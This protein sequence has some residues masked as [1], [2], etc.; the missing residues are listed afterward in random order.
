MKGRGTDNGLELADQRQTAES[1]EDD[2]AN[3]I[4][5]SNPL[6]PALSSEA[7]ER[8]KTVFEQCLAIA[9]PREELYNR[10][11]QRVE[12]MFAAG[13]IDEVQR[14]RQLPKPLSKEASQALGY[15]EIGD[16]LDGKRS[17]PETIAEIQLRSRQFAK[18]QLTWLRNL[19]GC[20]LVEGKLTFDLWRGKM[21]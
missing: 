15:R 11:N 20:L 3:R 17:L 21:S 6:T 16:L 9:I 4:P 12:A 14:L 5:K 19:P 13:W 10:I 7:G 1:P 2:H 8:E 18:R